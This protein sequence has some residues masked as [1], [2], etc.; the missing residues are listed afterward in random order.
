MNVDLK[1]NAI[2]IMLTTALSALA[3]SSYSQKDSIRFP[4]IQKHATRVMQFI[5]DGWHLIDSVYC[6]IKNGTLTTAEEC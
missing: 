5:P 1:N 2:R 4:V 3:Y 6:E